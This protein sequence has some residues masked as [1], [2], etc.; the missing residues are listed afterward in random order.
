M[1]WVFSGF[2]LGALIGTMA[3]CTDPFTVAEC[4]QEA[5]TWSVPGGL[6]GAVGAGIGIVVDFLS[7]HK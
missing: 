7:R 2:F 3:T 1:G 6:G 4:S 5:S